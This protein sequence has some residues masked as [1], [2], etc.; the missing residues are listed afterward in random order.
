[1]RVKSRCQAF[2]ISHIYPLK[3]PSILA[4][5]A[6][7]TTLSLNAPASASAAADLRARCFRAVFLVASLWTGLGSLVNL[8]IIGSTT[9]LAHRLHAAAGA[10]FT[11][12]A[13]IYSVAVPL[14]YITRPSV[15]DPAQ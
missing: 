5:I 2:Q 14:W 4:T 1:M 7:V 15:N 12:S 13:A 6:P 8:F 11:V 3:P 9:E 10:A